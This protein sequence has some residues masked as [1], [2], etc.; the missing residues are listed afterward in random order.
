MDNSFLKY[1]VLLVF[2]LSM[3]NGGLISALY[4]SKIFRK[5]IGLQ[6]GEPKRAWLTVQ[7]FNCDTVTG[8]CFI[9]TFSNK[10]IIAAGGVFPKISVTSPIMV[11]YVF[12]DLWSQLTSQHVLRSSAFPVFQN[13][14]RWLLFGSPSSAYSKARNIQN[15]RWGKDVLLSAG[16]LYW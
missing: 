5:N 12:P 2:V 3:R 14:S 10:S 16:Y 9:S 8:T 1:H 11:S 15:L 13:C 6:N 4:T 7:L